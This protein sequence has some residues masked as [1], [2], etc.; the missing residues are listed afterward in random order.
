MPKIPPCNQYSGPHFQ[1]KRN[2]K[3]FCRKG[4]KNKY[5]PQYPPCEQY[6]PNYFLYSKNDQKFCRKGNRKA[7]TLKKKPKKEKKSI[8]TT[9][10][11][12]QNQPNK[13]LRE[14]ANKLNIDTQKYQDNSWVC[15]NIDNM[16][17]FQAPGHL[18][19]K[20]TCKILG[21]KTR[22]KRII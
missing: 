22:N 6:G 1:Y 19:I 5:K 13:K 17:V 12:C 2:N 14:Y 11:K 8:K 15:D 9:G 10:K 16:V 4:N 3:V 20:E 21:I 18:L 7:K